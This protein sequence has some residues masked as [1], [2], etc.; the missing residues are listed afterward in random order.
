MIATMEVADG[1]SIPA[2]TDRTLVEI[3]DLYPYDFAG[4][5]VPLLDVAVP[6][7]D[8]DNT[9]DVPI[10]TTPVQRLP[11]DLPTVLAQLNKVTRGR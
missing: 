2:G 6:V 3:T 5:S 10:D 8:N 7:D 9:D 4:V 1:L 11:A